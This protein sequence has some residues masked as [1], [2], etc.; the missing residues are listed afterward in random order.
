MTARQ[1][2][3]SVLVAVH[4][5]AYVDIALEKGLGSVSLEHRDRGLVTELVYG[6]VRQ[7]RYLDALITP[8]C[9][10]PLE[11]Q[12]FPLGQILRLGF[13]QLRFL[14]QIPDH[15]VVH[16]TVEL[17]KTAGMP[18]LAAVVNGI[19]RAYLRDQRE[20]SLPPDLTAQLG[21]AHS[22]P[23]WLIDLWLPLLGRSQTEALCQWFNQPAPI[24]LR[25]NPLRSDRPSILLALQQMGIGAQALEGLPYGIHL[26]H[27]GIAIPDLP[28]YA[29]G[30]W[31]VQ[32]R[33][34]Q[35]VTY[36]LDPQPGETII[37]ACAAP[38]GKTTHIAEYMG[39]Q[40]QVI[41]CDRTASRLKKIGQNQTRLGLKSIQIS[42]GDSCQRPEFF[43]RGDRVLLDAPCSGI[44]TVHRHADARWRQTPAKIAE[45]IQLQA[46]LLDHT[47]TWVKPGGV[48]VYATCS[49]HPQENEQQ[50]IQFLGRHPQWQVI[51]PKATSPLAPLAQESGWIT[52]WP[53]RHNMDGFF[54]AALGYG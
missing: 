32:D 38:G 18:K 31:S 3:L 11:Q 15:A 23:D 14:S 8:Y 20:P 44:G 46:Q 49:L 43:Q 13:Y 27:A 53:Q 35:W 29:E 47:S 51:P 10:R 36:L 45:L 9:R 21:V 52:L 5:G 37:D 41:A 48:L 25:V 34:A 30:H 1:V 17:A 33:A 2:A 12:P 42:P 22:F 50:I 26:P 40:G 16:T 24:D 19:L 6:T 7:Q 4:R 54:I 28:G 39:D